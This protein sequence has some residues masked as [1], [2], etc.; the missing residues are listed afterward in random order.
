MA[1]WFSPKRYGCG[2]GLPM[3]WQGWVV[4]LVYLA[5]VMGGALLADRSP[6]AAASIIAP[7]TIL[8]LVICFRTTAGG[9]GCRWGSKK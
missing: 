2:S 4:M 1:E 7:A 9:W 8:F 3:S 5:V 6:V